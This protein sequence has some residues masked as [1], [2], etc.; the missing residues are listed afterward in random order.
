MRLAWTSF[1]F[2]YCLPFCIIDIFI[3][4]MMYL[5]LEFDGFVL[6]KNISKHIYN[7]NIG[8]IL[9]PVIDFE[10]DFRIFLINLGNNSYFNCQESRT[11]TFHARNNLLWPCAKNR[12][13]L[14]VNNK[15]R[16]KMQNSSN[17]HKTGGE[18]VIQVFNPQSQ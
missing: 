17:Y 4:F 3:C 7:Y 5:H 13:L 8:S 18:C 1:A 12:R 9:L 10:G 2:S 6:K 15:G 11:R 16:I 14:L